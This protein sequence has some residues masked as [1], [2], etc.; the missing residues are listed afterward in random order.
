MPRAC[1]IKYLLTGAIRLPDLDV[2]RCPPSLAHHICEPALGLRGRCGC[3]WHLGGKSQGHA[4][5]PNRQ[6][7]PTS[8]LRRCIYIIRQQKRRSQGASSLCP[9]CT[10]LHLPTPSAHIIHVYSPRASMK[11]CRITRPCRPSPNRLGPFRRL[12]VDLKYVY[13]TCGR[14][15]ARGRG[16]QYTCGA[17]PRDGAKETQVL[18]PC[19][20]HEVSCAVI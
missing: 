18:A 10:M 20:R 5:L 6:Q 2:S 12:A 1:R 16:V 13:C 3:T 19:H 17:D 11:H 14:A 4:P 9:C 15:D 8:R 7:E